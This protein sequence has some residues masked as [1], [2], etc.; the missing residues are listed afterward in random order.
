MVTTATILLSRAF[1]VTD[2]FVL[3]LLASL[4]LSANNYQSA[5]SILQITA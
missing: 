3:A 2:I 4:K 1:Y 5:M